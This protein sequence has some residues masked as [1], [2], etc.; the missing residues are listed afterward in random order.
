MVGREKLVT[1]IKFLKY[2]SMSVRGGVR[3]TMPS[4]FSLLK[5][6]ITNPSKHCSIVKYILHHRHNNERKRAKR[7]KA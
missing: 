5:V 4:P 6:F 3:F 7:E 1:V 2:V